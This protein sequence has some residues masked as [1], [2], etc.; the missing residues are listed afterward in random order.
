[1]FLYLGRRGAL[2]RFVLELAAA[3]AQFEELD[4]IIAISRANESAPKLAEFTDQIFTLDTFKRATPLS[5][6]ANF[7][8]VRRNLLARLERDRPLAVVT[9][10]PHVWTPLLAPAIKRLGIRYVTVIHDAVAHPGDPTAI[11]TPWLVREARCADLVITLCRTVADRLVS[12]GCASADRLLTLFHPDLTFGT[13]PAD[14]KRAPDKPLRLLFFGRILT[15]KGLPLLIDA[16]EMLRAEGIMVEL[17]VAGLGN[18]G[19]E[20]RRLTALGAEVINRWIE[21]DEIGP[22]LAR[23]DAMALSHIEASQSGVAAAAF[24]NCMPVVAM[25]VGGIAEQVVGART[26]VMADRI[27]ARSFADAIHRLA[28]D[29]ALYER[30]SRNL[31]ETAQDRSMARFIDELVAETIRLKA[32]AG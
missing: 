27:N 2:G 7:F 23:Y 13:V 28:V 30:I 6:V 21:D 29:P 4:A 24:G 11:V 3:A 5:I 14:R 26:G 10:M 15:Y 22:L 25:P 18:I 20:R 8:S 9:L 17:G 1:M 19:P 16:V 12:I 32:L 31:R